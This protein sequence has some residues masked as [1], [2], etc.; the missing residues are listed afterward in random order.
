VTYSAP[1]GFS[2]IFL[3]ASDKGDED[4]APFSLIRSTAEE[5]QISPQ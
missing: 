1:S 3:I 4:G 2:S 5:R